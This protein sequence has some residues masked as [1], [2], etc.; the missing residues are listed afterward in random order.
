M[1]NEITLPKWFDGTVYE[2]GDIVHNI[3]SKESYYLDNKLLSMY[4]MIIGA[5]Y[6]GNY[7]L[8]RKGLDWFRK[9]APEAYMVL[10]D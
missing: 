5:Q 7:T 9:A 1:K 6:V 10:L 2:E 3:L 8:L 4:D